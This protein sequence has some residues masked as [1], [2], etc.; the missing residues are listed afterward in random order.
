MVI[1]P[2]LEAYGGLRLR[3]TS[4]VLADSV[5]VTNGTITSGAVADTQTIN[6]VYL[7]VQ[8]TGK[9]EI[10]F[11]FVGLI[12]LPVRLEVLGRYEGNPAHN[13]FLEI[14]NYNTTAWDR[15]TAEATDFPDSAVDADYFFRLPQSADYL[16]GGECQVRIRHDSAVVNSH[17]MYV[18]YIEIH[19]ATLM[20]PVPGTHYQ[21]QDL[22]PT[23]SGHMDIDGPA[24][25]ITILESGDYVFGGSISFSGT[26]YA[27]IRG[28]LQVNGVDAGVAFKRRLGPSGDTGSAS[29]GPNIIPLSVGDVLTF[30]FEA[31]VADAY[32]SI[33]L[34]NVS[35][36]KL[37]T[38]L[39][40]RA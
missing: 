5:A 2:V 3:Q 33:D 25:E 38:K 22:S 27:L 11:T 30:W 28:Y 34:L 14:Y 35:L 40:L 26:D 32:L 6:Q 31:D 37:D 24:G 39:P 9:F 16:S 10:A 7:E 8:E 21:L 12:G 18:D 19:Q 20:L 36:H 29:G 1:H 15:V 4:Q 17:Y 23:A 13:V